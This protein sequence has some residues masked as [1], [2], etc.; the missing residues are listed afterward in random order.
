MEF[1]DRDVAHCSSDSPVGVARRKS[2]Q[3]RC[4]ALTSQEIG[5][6]VDNT[7]SQLASWPASQLAS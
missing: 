4:K 6:E 5:N 3:P 2:C 7:A 1:Q